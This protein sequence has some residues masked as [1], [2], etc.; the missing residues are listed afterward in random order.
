MMREAAV[1]E[2]G[3]DQRHE[4]FLVAGEAARHERRAERE[5]Q[6]HR[7]DRLLLVGLA[8]LR[9]RAD[10]RRRRELALG[11]AVDAVVLEDVHHVEVAAD[12]V[13]ELP[14]AD[15]QR[16]AVA[17]D[18]DVAQVAVRRIGAGRDRRH[19][20]VH[21][22][23]PVRAADEIGRRFR[24]AADAGQLDDA[25]RRQRELEAGLH[26]RG[27]HRVVAAAGAERRH[28]ALVVAAVEAER[29]PRQA[30]VRDFR[31]GDEAHAATPR[32]S[33]WLTPSTMQEGG[34]GRPS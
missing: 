29:I 25:L 33:S 9:L 19:A 17:R 16:I 4:L 22:V 15:R 12:G 32:A 18:A 31:L 14:D 6:Q 20:P 13:R 1:R 5:R 24:R 7:V 27:R 28:A 8:L 10:V 3:L 26:D 23:E 21:R 11:Q 2:A 34:I 30:G